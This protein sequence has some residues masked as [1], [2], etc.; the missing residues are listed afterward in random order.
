METSIRMEPVMNDWLWGLRIPLSLFHLCV[1]SVLTLRDPRSWPL[2][3]Q[4]GGNLF[5]VATFVGRAARLRIRPLAIRD[6]I[7]LN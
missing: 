1:C 2:H 6:T 7:S 4:R 3:A 5:D